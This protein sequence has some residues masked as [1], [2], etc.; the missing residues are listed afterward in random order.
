LVEK[1]AGASRLARGKIA[2]VKTSHFIRHG[3]SPFLKS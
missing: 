3:R 1:V 2:A